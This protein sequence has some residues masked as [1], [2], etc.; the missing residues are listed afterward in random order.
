MK[1]KMETVLKGLVGGMLSAYCIIY[2]LRPAAPYPEII[3]EIFENPFMF[4][5]LLIINY[6][7]FV[8]DNHSGAVLLLCIIALV[9]DYIVFTV[10]GFKRVVKVERFT[11]KFPEEDTETADVK[12]E[13]TETDTGDSET[14]TETDSA[15]NNKGST[16]TLI[17]K[18]MNTKQF[19]FDTKSIKLNE[20]APFF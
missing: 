19:K 8:W 3:L 7:V 15:S 12:K 9:F 11:N 13:N 14:E 16:D 18:L 17:S 20:P 4:L 2:A 1:V 5:I 6:Y 10:K